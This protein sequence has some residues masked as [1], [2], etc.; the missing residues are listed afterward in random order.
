[1]NRQMQ[2]YYGIAEAFFSQPLPVWT[3][4]ERLDT[5]KFSRE[6]APNVNT[7]LYCPKD[8]P[9]VTKWWGRLYPPDKLEALRVA[10]NF[11]N[12]NGITFIFGLNP[13]QTMLEARKSSTGIQRVRAK[14]QQLREVGCTSFCLLF[15]DIP[16][17]YDVVSATSLGAAE[18][19]LDVMVAVTNAIF[20]SLQSVT[21]WF[22][23]PDYCFRQQ[24]PVTQKMKLLDPGIAI[25]WTGNDIFTKRV[26]SND[27][28]RVRRLLGSSRRLILWSNYPVNDY[29][30]A[31][32]QFNLGGF[33]PVS[34][35]VLKEL[36]GIM[37]NPMR[38]A[39]A[40]LPFY[41]TFSSFL[42]GPRT[43]SRSNAWQRAL[44]Q[45]VAGR[46]KAYE[47]IFREFGQRNV[48]DVRRDLA[49]SGRAI[50]VLR[51]ALQSYTRVDK[52]TIWLRRFALATSSVLRDAQDWV[53]LCAALRTMTDVSACFRRFDRF[54]TDAAVARF[55]PE[56]Y[57]IVTERLKLLPYELLRGSQS[58]LDELCELYSAFQTTFIGGAKLAMKSQDQI[59]Y[60]K[61]SKRAVQLESEL[62]LTYLLRD[63]R[64]T[65]EKLAYLSRRQNIN[66]FAISK[67]SEQA[68]REAYQPVT[69]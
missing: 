39:Y 20:R 53:D 10:I 30:Q 58:E 11:C 22:C 21:F 23:G 33:P 24:T 51:R 3:P 9:Y 4:K 1:M 31:V 8:D 42:A 12:Q 2:R 34:N 7:Y 27:V 35:T 19:T 26:T 13:D 28:R 67:Q 46:A 37:V 40:N 61:A 56:C 63:D 38:E 62:A 44:Q 65:K 18:K 41:M 17:A 45:I 25:L 5:L 29:E 68:E 6:Y 69:I 55:F 64:K 66:R 59:T 36:D 47:T 32:G 52:D 54:P 48:V 14:L 15:D 16:V 49:Q 57:R 60:R 50:A 43:Y